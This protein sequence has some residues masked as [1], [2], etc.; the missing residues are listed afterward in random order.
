MATKRS[1]CPKW[2]MKPCCLPIIRL[3]Y[4]HTSSD[5]ISP[6]HCLGLPF[7]WLEPI[8]NKDPSK[9]QMAVKISLQQSFKLAQ[10]LTVVSIEPT[11]Q[12]RNMKKYV[13]KQ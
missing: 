6:L 9:A 13:N 3:K 4:M 10:F 1:S 5:S 8:P 12:Y 11:C 7:F 2:N